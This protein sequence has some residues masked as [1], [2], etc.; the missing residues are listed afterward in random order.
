[1][2]QLN[3]KLLK[4]EASQRLSECR[5]DPRKL[6]VVYTGV[7]MVLSLLVNGLTLYLDSQI[8]QTG[9]LSGLGA[10][11]VLET[12]QTLLSYFT[13]LFTPFWS[14]AMLSSVIAIVRHG[15]ADPANFRGGF[16]PR[17]LIFSLLELSITFLLIM[18]CTY[19]A[20]YIFLMT[21]MAE[22]LKAMIES[23]ELISAAGEINM[24]L[25]T[26]DLVFQIAVPL[27]GI[28]LALFV[29]LYVFFLYSIRLALFLLVEGLPTRPM[30]AIMASFMLM[31]RHR[32][33]LFK[34]DLSFWWY[35]LLNSL[36][37]VVAYLDV[38][39]PNLGITLPFNDTVAYFVALILSLVCQLALD[40]WKKPEVDT[41]YV[42]AYDA[43]AHPESPD[44]LGFAKP[45]PVTEE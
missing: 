4:A 13:M 20:C 29:P 8:S 27:I 31:R 15:E 2:S 37:S 36:I 34:L 40:L 14:A 6:I 18:I 43:I 23:G 28:F 17:V 24:D 30:S 12:L 19:A 35:Y 45:A 41:A 9:G 11:S 44:H 3:P 7:V 39:L 1:M 26:D 22:S 38:L 10:R 16:K 32:Y 5:G 25:F 42:L 21:P 33:Q